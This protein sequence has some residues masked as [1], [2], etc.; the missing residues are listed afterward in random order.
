M[1]GA[2]VASRA[3][4]N[5][6]KGKQQDF[7]EYQKEMLKIF[8]ASWNASEQLSRKV[9]LQYSDARIDQGVSSLKYLTTAEILDILSKYRF[10]QYLKGIKAYL[11][12]KNY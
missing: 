2:E 6:L 7:R 11:W 4:D 1:F 3:I 5:Y 12:K 9:Y 10:E 8:Q